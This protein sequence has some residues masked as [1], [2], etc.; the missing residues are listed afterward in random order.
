MSSKRKSGIP[1]VAGVVGC[2]GVSQVIHLPIL[3]KHTDIKIK[4]LCDIDTS[5]A[6][7][8]AN[9]FNIPKV[10]EDI[11]EMLNREQLDVV[12]I[13]TPN[14]MHLPMSLLALDHDVHVFIEK[15]AARNAAEV[16]R[17]KK[18][19]EVLDKTVMVGMQ[20]RFRPDVLALHRFIVGNELGNPFF[21]KA[22]W[23]HAQ[24]QAVKQAWLFNKNVSGGGVLMDLG[25]QLID[26]VWWLLGKPQPT[27]V[28]S[29]SYKINNE[30]KVEDFCVAFITFREDIS[31]SVEISWDFPISQDIFYLEIIGEK[32][33]GTLNPVKLQKLMHGQIMNIIPDLQETKIGHFK[34]GYQNE[35]NHFIDFLVGRVDRLES[36]ID[37]AIQVQ[38]IVDG[39]YKSIEEK[40]EI[41]L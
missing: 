16:K 8:I 36:N 41:K 35:V 2:G 38:K 21:I 24:H 33:I 22:G 11:A 20:N 3:K 37:D 10:Y 7:I 27:C 15:P 25:V 30:L 17:I 40:K 29:F 4:A 32:G 23:L 1:L 34:M 9:K 12:F 28:K 13:L 19:A 31:F 14:N 6:S 5:K 39:I 18:H 26:M